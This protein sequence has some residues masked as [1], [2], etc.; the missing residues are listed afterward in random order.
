MRKQPLAQ[1]GFDET[2]CTLNNGAPVQDHLGPP[3]FADLRP[4]AGVLVYDLA[5]WRN[6]EHSYTDQLFEW[7]RKNGEDR[8][9]TLG[10]QPPFNLV[11][12]RPL[13]MIPR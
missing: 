5:A 2:T 6:A 3:Y 10:S 8:L 13:P 12:S 7:T 11:V 4:F 9:Y 1:E